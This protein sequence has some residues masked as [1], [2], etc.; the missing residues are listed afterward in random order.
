MEKVLTIVVPSYNA[1][2]YL[3][4]T[5]PT[6]LN[7]PYLEQL[8]I[9]IVNDGS[10]DETK[11]IAERFAEGY[12]KTVKVINKVNGGHGSTINVGIHQAT[13]KYF[14]VIDADDW[15][16]SDGLT[17]LIKDLS[18]SDA[19]LVVSDYEEVYENL[20]TRK[21]KAFDL[22]NNVQQSYEQMLEKINQIPPMHATTF[23]TCLLKDN[24]IKIDEN[25][26]Y[27]DEEYIVFPI[28]HVKTCLYKKGVVYRYRLGTSTQSVSLRSSVKN[29]AM[30]A[31]V[32]LALAKYYATNHLSSEKSM[33]LRKHICG[34]VGML[35][36]IY[37]LMEDTSLAKEEYLKFENELKEISFELYEDKTSKI[38]YLLRKTNYRVFLMLSLYVKM[39]VK[40]K[41]VL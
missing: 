27:V 16:D 24:A 40:Y 15:V 20:G 39:R 38:S 4:E 6:I 29:R 19:D 12:P 31:N 26:F 7:S 5:I 33:I 11:E 14:K 30:K 22:P 10:K 21:I 32:L 36:K 23:K 41:G 25:S 35:A 3:P 34:G 1:E 2:Q 8:E 17:Q 9:L 37:L 13:G 18:H 28:K